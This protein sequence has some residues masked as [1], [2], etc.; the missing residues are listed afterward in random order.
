MLM[1]PPWLN[2]RHSAGKLG[3][4]HSSH[5]SFP[6]SFR[7]HKRTCSHAHTRTTHMHTLTQAHTHSHTHNHMH[8]HTYQPC[9]GLILFSSLFSQNTKQDCV[10]VSTPLSLPVNR[11]NTALLQEP[12]PSPP[13]PILLRCSG[14]CVL[15]WRCPCEQKH[16]PP[17]FLDPTPAL[18]CP[19]SPPGCDAAT[20]GA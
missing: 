20:E 15:R 1:L 8:R 3:A 4:P 5:H 14:I 17:R 19:E 13:P 11:G 10:T 9:L 7:T 18:L 16:P 12:G 6:A 2:P